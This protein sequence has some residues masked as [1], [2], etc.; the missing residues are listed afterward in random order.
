MLTRQLLSFSIIG[1]VGLIVDTTVLYLSFGLLGLGLYGGRV[2][3]YLAAA[4]AT[5]ALNRKYT[6]RAFRSD[7][8]AAE[9]L[10]FLA[11]NGV[12]GI[13]NYVV[14]AGLVAG[15][16]V[17]REWPVLG[18]AAGSLAGLTANFTLS[19]LVVFKNRGPHASH[20][21]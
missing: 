12:G 9:W 13:I 1:V 6:F 18:V 2:V 5:W 7:N 19:K 8:Y 14:Y 10:R 20:Q 4:T 3:S 11:A 17:V 15:V 16:D 21:S